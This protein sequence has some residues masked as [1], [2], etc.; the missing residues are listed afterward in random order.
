MI[1]A[2]YIYEIRKLK[3]GKT[4]SSQN[5]DLQINH[6]MCYY[7]LNFNLLPNLLTIM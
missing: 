7:R 2:I 4:Y 5:I 1:T 3:I 6:K